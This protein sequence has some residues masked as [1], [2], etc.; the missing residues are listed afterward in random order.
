LAEIVRDGNFAQTL[1]TG[2]A[3]GLSTMALAGVHAERGAGDH[4]AIDFTEYEHFEGIGALNLKRAGL[5][6]YVEVIAERSELVLPR[7]AAEGLTRDFVFI[8]GSHLFDW[9]VIDFFYADRLLDVGGVIAL[10]DTLMPAVRRAIDFVSSN[11]AYEQLPATNTNLAVLRKLA[12]DTR[13]WDHY[14]AW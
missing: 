4:I 13:E 7:L 6:D 10:H 1:E 8:D 14:V 5:E 2:M 11:L 3:Y 9:V 12:V